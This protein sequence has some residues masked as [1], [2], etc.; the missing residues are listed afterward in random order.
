MNLTFILCLFSRGGFI[1]REPPLSHVRNLFTL[2]FHQSVWLTLIA[3]LVIILVLLVV[4]TNWERKKYSVE[5]DYLISSP[6]PIIDNILL[7]IG[8]IS[9]QGNIR[10]TIIISIHL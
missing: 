6:T 8:A 2:P 1:F 10:I 4:T 7:V 5:N 3:L 9:Q